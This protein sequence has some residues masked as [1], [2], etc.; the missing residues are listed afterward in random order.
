MSPLGM[1]QAP[2]SSRFAPYQDMHPSSKSI[3]LDC[4]RLDNAPQ[5]LGI[6]L[7]TP[8]DVEKFVAHCKLQK[9]FGAAGGVT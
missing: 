2:S 3:G 5:T 1:G 9:R 8:I 7:V 6:N 4:P